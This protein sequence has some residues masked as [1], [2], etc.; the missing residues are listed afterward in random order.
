MAIFRI[1]WFSPTLA[2]WQLFSCPSDMTE[3]LEILLGE[4]SIAVFLAFSWILLAKYCHHLTWFIMCEITTLKIF[5][6]SLHRMRILNH[7]TCLWQPC[8]E[9]KRKQMLQ[10]HLL[11]SIKRAFLLG[12]VWY[13]LSPMKNLAG[14][15]PVQRSSFAL[16]SRSLWCVGQ[17]FTRLLSFL[18][19]DSVKMAISTLWVRLSQDSSSLW[20]LVALQHLT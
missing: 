8:L 6:L 7:N 9:N 11:N 18:R 3:L 1:R 16:P 2:A 15:L 14:I 12:R 5:S 19:T 10:N 17:T 4:K 20:L 13:V